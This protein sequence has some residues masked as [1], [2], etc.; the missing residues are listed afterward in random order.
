[1]KYAEIGEIMGIT[2]GAA[3]V[4]VH[5]AVQ[6]LKQIYLKKELKTGTR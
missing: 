5:R 1:L 3:K 6:E 4:R 2:A